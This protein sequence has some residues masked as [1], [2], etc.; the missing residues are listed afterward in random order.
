[1]KTVALIWGV[2]ALCAGVVVASVFPFVAEIN[3][4]SLLFTTLVLGVFSLLLF[5]YR[6]KGIFLTVCCCVFLI[7]L[8]LLRSTQIMQDLNNSPLHKLTNTSATLTGT[9]TGTIDER[10]TNTKF[11]LDT[12]DGKI[13]VSNER[14]MNIETGDLITL[15]GRLVQPRS[16]ETDTGRTFDYAGY[17]LKDG[18]TH[19]MS[20]PEIMEITPGTFSIAKSLFRLKKSLI[21]SA[22]QFIPYPEAGLLSGILYGEKGG[23]GDKLMKDFRTTGIVHIVVLSGYNVTI[24]AIFFLNIFS[25]INRR[26]GLA[27]GG[28]SIITFAILTGGGA[29][30]IRASIMAILAVA[31]TWY[32]RD[33]DITRSLALAGGIMIL[34]NPLI[35][36]FD[37][38]FQLSFLATIGLVYVGPIIKKY[39]MWVPQKLELRENLLAT[40]STQ[41]FVLPLLMYA[42]GEVSL[43]SI[44]VNLIVL[45]FIPAAMLLGFITALL[46][47]FAGP[48]T[49]IAAAPTYLLLWI[50][51]KIVEIFSGIP[52]AAVSLPEI[53]FWSVLLLYILLFW[54]VWWRHK[55]N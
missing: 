26:L 33:Y 27:L 8:G 20:K 2:C 1:M 15:R 55:R 30:I 9:I 11:I 29:T 40:V 42:T 51:M 23:L 16:F 25:R 24:I 54:W 47:F 48:L 4:R 36:V 17:L 14:H 31:A 32:G 13:L 41:I 18:I 10:Q 44:L 6:L 43:V 19:R 45:P 35:L 34:Q 46:G 21:R 3:I 52:H 38:S 7:C 50:P 5:L 49:W 37:I 28:L 22:S 53:P 12:G 39:L